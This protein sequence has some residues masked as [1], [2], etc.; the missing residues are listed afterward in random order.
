VV[1]D[2]H[3]DLGIEDKPEQSWNCDEKGVQDQFDKG[4]G[5]GE[6][7]QPSFSITPGE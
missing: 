6:V 7:D 2:L 3:K 5:I 1:K 4:L